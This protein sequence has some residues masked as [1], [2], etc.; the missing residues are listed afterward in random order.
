MA[1][2][3]N[4][5]QLNNMYVA[6]FETCDADKVY[7]YDLSTGIEIK[8]QKVWLAG[9]KNLE[10]M[11]STYFTSLEDFMN[12]ILSRGD[13]VNTEYAFHNIKFDGSYIIPYLLKNYSV[14]TEKPQAGEFS[15]LVDNRN[16][17]YS[18]TI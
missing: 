14:T 7:K 6:D 17:W 12:A 13:N 2:R 15:V 5:V 10:T 16:Y 9:F 18:I 3:G 4:T 1:S 11:E 8:E